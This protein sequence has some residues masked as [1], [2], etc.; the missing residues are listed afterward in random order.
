MPARWRVRWVV[1]REPSTRSGPAA[2]A[3]A[4]CD[5][6]PPHAT[7]PS[8]PA[9]TT[10]LAL[11]QRLLTLHQRVRTVAAA[12]RYGNNCPETHGKGRGP[13]TCGEHGK[14]ERDW[15][16]ALDGDMRALIRYRVRGFG[17]PARAWSVQLP[18]RH[19]VRGSAPK[20]RRLPH[21]RAHIHTHV[22]VRVRAR[23]YT[24][25]LCSG[26]IDCSGWPCW[27]DLMSTGT[28]SRPSSLT[29]PAAVLG[30]TCRP[31]KEQ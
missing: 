5:K 4:N 23:T 1:H 15:P 26:V 29:T 17:S 16:E 10:S 30:P 25:C 28:V 11:A 14:L 9:A 24:T 2:T 20:Q 3:E 31:V 7:A 21:A 18:T 6:A 27:L 8:R 22:R 19:H 12:S 13:S